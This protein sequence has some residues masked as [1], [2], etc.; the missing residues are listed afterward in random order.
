MISPGRNLFRMLQQ[1]KYFAATRAGVAYD[2][3]DELPEERKQQYERAAHSLI[4]RGSE[5]ER[6]GKLFDPNAATIAPPPPR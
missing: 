3:W 4:M 6:S 1:G 2:Y 5:L